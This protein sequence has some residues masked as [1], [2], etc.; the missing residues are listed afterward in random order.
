MDE[1]GTKKQ[2]AA[3]Y[4]SASPTQHKETRAKTHGLRNPCVQ[5]TACS[6]CVCG[7]PRRSI[8]VF[9]ADTKRLIITI[10]RQI[11]GY[12][13]K[14]HKSLS[15]NSQLEAL[16]TAA[17]LPKR[18]ASW[19]RPSDLYPPTRPRHW[20]TSLWDDRA[21]LHKGTK[22]K[23]KKKGV[24]IFKAV[25]AAPSLYFIAP[26]LALT[27]IVWQESKIFY[28]LRNSSGLLNAGDS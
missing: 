11:F 10:G 25:L 27:N 26:R 2:L 4:W 28:S 13:H 16:R 22:V 6:A 20:N 9:E 3:G 18:L 8:Q 23:T 14:S 21:L 17:P 12:T 19:G 15:S 5:D 24:R 7:S 1:G